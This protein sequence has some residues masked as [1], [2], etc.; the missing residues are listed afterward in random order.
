VR[1][2][3]AAGDA[4]KGANEIDVDEMSREVSSVAARLQVCVRLRAR[5]RVF[6]RRGRPNAERERVLT[7]QQR[8]GRPDA[9]WQQQENHRLQTQWLAAK[10]ELRQL[11]HAANQAMAA[12]KRQHDMRSSHDLDSKM[13]AL[14]QDLSALLPDEVPPAP[15]P[16]PEALLENGGGGGD[17]AEESPPPSKEEHTALERGGEEVSMKEIKE[18]LLEANSRLL[19]MEQHVS[20][21]L[22]DRLEDAGGAPLQLQAPGLPPLPHAVAGTPATTPFHGMQPPWS[23]AALERDM[24]A[25]SDDAGTG[26]GRE[27][28]LRMRIAQLERLLLQQQLPRPYTPAGPP[29]SWGQAACPESATSGAGGEGGQQETSNATDE[30]P[31]CDTAAGQRPGQARQGGGAAE[32]QRVARRS[33]REER[34]LADL[35]ASRPKAPQEDAGGVA[36][37]GSPGAAAALQHASMASPPSS[38]PLRRHTPERAEE[39]CEALENE[40]PPAVDRA[41]DRAA[42]SA[43]AD[44]AVHDAR[45]AAP[46]RLVVTVERAEGLPQM[47]RL[48]R[49]ADPYLVLSVDGAVEVT[50]CKAK[51][52]APVWRESFSFHCFE[53]VSVLHVEMFDKETVGKDRSMGTFSVIVR[54]SIGGEERAGYAL[55]GTLFNKRPATGTVFLSLAFLDQH[56]PAG[57]AA[58]HG[59]AG[60]ASAPEL[61]HPA[62]LDAS[63]GQSVLER[64]QEEETEETGDKHGRAQAEAQLQEQEEAKAGPTVA[65]S[66][67]ERLATFAAWPFSERAAGGAYP[68]A[69]QLAAAGFVYT[70]DSDSLDAVTCV[71]CSARLAAWEGVKDPFSVHALVS[72]DC[73]EAFSPIL[74]RAGGEG[75]GGAR[76]EREGAKEEMEREGRAGPGPGATEGARRQAAGD[77]GE[78]PEAAIIQASRWPA[79]G[80]AAVA[81]AS[82][83]RPRAV[84]LLAA[85]ELPASLPACCCCCCCCCYRGR[86]LA[87]RRDGG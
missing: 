2:L 75:H 16:L 15:T 45:Y 18:G 39:A 80:G 86:G 57:T 22:A 79:R 85:T 33:P 59:A 46:G 26:P 62:I 25:D 13:M 43:H 4:T 65:M 27:M 66:A 40:L 31:P 32:P 73:H 52:L 41:V 47:D 83:A 77:G 49:K 53:G 36:A 42:A 8:W 54:R 87:L 70:P 68:S 48:T 21:L 61:D 55:Q 58:A 35:L 64:V 34:A 82:L 56:H 44:E 84:G 71:K 6:Q 14:S 78:A 11:R 74:A 81:L 1:V 3:C 38:S 60:D 17:V 12:R 9:A 28:Q 5:R 76:A 24:A 19:K 69:R 23:G 51:T 67:D 72:P 63:R 37:T 7:R 20:I 10:R 50:S 30:Q 29:P